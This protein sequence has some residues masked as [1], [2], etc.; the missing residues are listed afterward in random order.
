MARTNIP[1]RFADDDGRILSATELQQIDIF[2]DIPFKKLNSIPGTVVER[3]FDAGQIICSQ[4]DS[5]YTAFYL[6]EGEVE[7]FIETGGGRRSSRPVKRRGGLIAAIGRMFGQK[8]F[9]QQ[10]LAYQPA[11]LI[12]IDASIDLE[13]GRMAAT[14][15]KNEV[16]GEMSCM[17]LAPRSATVVTKTPCVML[18][19]LRNM[20]GVLLKEGAT[21]KEQMDAKY[22]ERMLASHLRN[23]PPFAEMKPDDIELMRLRAE[24]VTYHPGDV[25]VREGEEAD[26]MYI[27][28]L[29]Q[30]KVT[31]HAP[32]GE[33]TLR[34]LGKG[35]CFGETA[36]LRKARRNATITAIDHPMFEQRVQQERATRIELVKID[37]ALVEDVLRKYPKIRGRLETEAELRIRD[38]KTQATVPLSPTHSQ[39]VEDMG[40]LQGMNLMLIDLNSCTRCDQ[41][42]TAC[43]E[44]HD[45]GIPRI[46]REGERYN[47]YLVPSS[48]RMC[49]DPVCMIGCPV[50]SIRRLDNMSIVIEDWCIGCT[51]CAQQCP[52]DAIQ[53]H[54]IE[55]FGRE[56]TE[57]LNRVSSSGEV[58]SVTR[59]AVV[60][61]QCSTL[62]TGPACV[63]ACPHDSAMR[64]NASDFL[65]E[66]GKARLNRP[67]TTRP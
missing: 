61:D 66:K 57:Q 47:N 6:M 45:D 46:F 4:G 5:G 34:Y 64:V 39:R 49:H 55:A 51:I 18:E 48:C 35:E 38:Q 50:G 30:V 67:K 10:A 58:K 2:R 36:L 25:I 54:D 27:V 33:R 7:I 60:C 8:N 40:L 26:A 32:G 42:V 22:R 21:F 20:Y 31:Q 14:L 17:N 56:A 16:F 43:I 1:A 37:R 44:S 65:G 3:Q 59:Q 15:G 52:Y 41:C 28:R 24:L 29:G 19:M 53:M 12:P 62:P 23:A 63:Y 13:Y 11:S 9:S